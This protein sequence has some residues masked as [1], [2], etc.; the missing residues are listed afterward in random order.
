MVTYVFARHGHIGMDVVLDNMT[1]C[2][3]SYSDD[4]IA[5]V[6][7]KFGIRE[8]VYYSPSM[9]RAS[10]FGFENDDDARNLWESALKKVDI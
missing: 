2:V 3:Q 8:E 1:F 10:D 9:D 6:I 7:K 4:S 5:G